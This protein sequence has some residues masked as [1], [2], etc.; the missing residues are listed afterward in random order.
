MFLQKIESKNAPKPVGAYSPA[1]KLGDFVYMSGQLGLDP[2]TNELVEGI[3]NQTRQ[4]ME[5]IKALLNE[6]GLDMHHIVK[7][8]ILL[9]N[10][11]DFQKVNEIYGAYF[12]GVYPA[13]SAFE[14]ARL[15]KNALVE[16]ECLVIDTLMYERQQEGCGGCGGH[17]GEGC[18]DDCGCEGC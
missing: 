3:E 6:K 17:E 13:R 5:N 14:V 9:D 4:V 2:N 8:T 7:T 11:D 1:V 15:P 16:I 10:I 18:G 12:E